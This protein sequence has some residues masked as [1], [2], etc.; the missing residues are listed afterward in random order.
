VDA[1][2]VVQASD[3]RAETLDLLA[4]DEPRTKTVGWVDL[5]RDDVPAQIAELENKGK[6]VGV[7]H[8][9]QVEPD[10]EWLRRSEV[11][12]GLAA[13]DVCFDL[14]ISP[15]QLP[16]VT[17]TVAALPG[18]RFV[19]DHA[20][21][22]PIRSGDL[23]TWRADIAALAAYP[24]V[25]VKISGLVTEADHARWVPGD[26]APVIDHVYAEFGADRTML[27]SDWPVCLL[28]ADYPSVRATTVPLLDRLSAAD[29]A[30]L[31]G[32]TALE[33]YR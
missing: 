5:T 21:K 6:L 19:L 7:R 11:R 29:R 1:A 22:P 32:G 13:L 31:E 3:T 33:W 16:L 4:A 9:L 8:N 25:A 30:R 2:I 14:V 24:N 15:E 10:K 27:G 28:A 17:E 26:L 20:G 23:S 18:T 12:N